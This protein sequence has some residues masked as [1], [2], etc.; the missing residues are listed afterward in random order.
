MKKNV[1][2]EFIAKLIEDYEIGTQA[3]LTNALREHGFDVTQATVSRDINEMHLIKVKGET[4]RQKYAVKT[5]LAKNDKY[6]N[7]FKESV[8]SIDCAENLII[9]KTYEGSAS[10]IGFFIDKSNIDGVLGCIS[11][12]DTILVITKSTDYAKKVYNRLSEYRKK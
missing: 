7:I 5:T 11:G 1:R 4:K 2:Q 12:D 8:V 6:V 10:A 9:I 3:E